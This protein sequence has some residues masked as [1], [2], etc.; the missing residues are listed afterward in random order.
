MR[1][2]LLSGMFLTF[3]IVIGELTMASLLAWPALGPY[4]SLIGQNRA[5]EPAALAIMSFALTWIAIILIEPKSRSIVP[6]RPTPT[7]SRSASTSSVRFR[8]FSRRRQPRPV[9]R[10]RAG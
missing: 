10:R 2:S 6:I 7:I 3:A 8:R 4:M 1:V 9:P 5:Y